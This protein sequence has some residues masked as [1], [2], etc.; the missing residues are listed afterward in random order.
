MRP[1]R[2]S[3]ATNE[4]QADVVC[5]RPRIHRATDGFAAIVDGDRVRRT[6]VLY[7]A[8]Q[9]RG[10]LDARDRAVSFVTIAS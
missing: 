9:R 5:V 8:V 6:T 3:L 1:I 10:D 4:I 2:N 7:D